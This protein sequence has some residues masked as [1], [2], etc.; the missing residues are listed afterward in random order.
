[1]SRGSRSS[2]RAKAIDGL[3]EIMSK[4]YYENQTPAQIFHP[5]ADSV[6]Y[7][8]RA[9]VL[10]GTAA[11]QA[12]LEAAILKRFVPLDGNERRALFKSENA[13]LSAFAAQIKLGYALGIYEGMFR[14]DLNMIRHIRNAFAHCGD[15][16]DFDT[17]QVTAAC[18]VLNYQHSKEFYWLKERAWATATP[19]SIFT[20]TA[21]FMIFPL[22]GRRKRVRIKDAEFYAGP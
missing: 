2:P 20:N 12:V 5:R 3:N 11:L 13:P 8:D 17:P 18:M 15:H 22:L 6:K 21:K 7:T 14:D 1:M 9:S 4:T 16:I 19:G 10:V